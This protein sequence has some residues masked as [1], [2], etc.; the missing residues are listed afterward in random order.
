[1]EMMSEST[2]KGKGK[3]KGDKGK[4]K[5]KMKGKF[6]GKGKGKLKG[7]G[8]GK[9]KMVPRIEE[10]AVQELPPLSPIHGGERARNAG[11]HTIEIYTPQY[12]VKQTEMEEYDARPDRLGPS[13]IGK[14]TKGIGQVEARFC[15]DDEDPVS[16]AMTVVHRLAERINDKQLNMNETWKYSLDQKNVNFWNAVGRLD[17][18]TESI[19]DRSKSMK[20]YCMDLFE[21]YGNEW[22]IEGVDQYNAC[23]GGQ[24][25]GL[26]TL[27]WMQ[28]EHWDGRYGIAIATDISEAEPSYFA[29]VGACVSASL[30]YPDAPLA[31]HSLRA[32]CILHRF[33][34]CKPAGWISMAPVTEGKYS[35]E[36]YM[37]AI[38]CCYKSLRLKLGDRDV[39]DITD[40]NVFH[41]GGG[42]HIVRKAFDRLL[43]GEL[44]GIKAA[45]KEALVDRRLH[46]SVHLL[47][48]IGPVH[49]VSSFCNIS[50]VTMSE[51][52]NAIGKVLMVFTYGSGCASSI[53]QVRYDDLSYMEPLMVWKSKFYRHAIHMDPEPGSLIHLKYC[54]VWMKFDYIPHGRQDFEQDLNLLEEDVYYLMQI[55]AFGRRFYHRGGLKAGP[56]DKKW[57]LEV[58]SAESR[59]KRWDF[60]APPLPPPPEKEKTQDD[61]WRELELQVLRDPTLEQAGVDTLGTDLPDKYY[62]TAV[63]IKVPT[64][65]ENKSNPSVEPDGRRHTYQIVGSW[66][67]SGVPEEMLE[68][69]G[70]RFLFEFTMGENRFEQFY[71]IQD[72]DEKRRIYPYVEK[73]SKDMPCIGPHHGGHGHVWVVDG[74]SRATV[75]EEERG[76]PGDKYLI[77]FRWPKK[78]IKSLTW[79]RIDGQSSEPVA[80]QYYVCAS[81]TDWEFEEL[82]AV[83]GGGRSE[84]WFS[85]EVQMTSLGLE[86][87][88]VRNK[89]MS[90]CIYPLDDGSP[91]TSRSAI[92]GPD[93]QQATPWKI[94]DKLGAVYKISFF[95]DLEDCESTAMRLKWTKLGQR[96][97]VE[98]NARYYI[99]GDFN[100]W[101]VS[102]F[103][104]MSNAEK[105]GVYEAVVTYGDEVLA[106]Q[107]LQHK[108]PNRCLHPSVD[109]C[110]QQQ[111][112][113]V[114][115][116]GDCSDEATRKAW[117]IGKHVSDKAKQG[118]KFN[119]RLETNEK[120]FFVSWTR[121]LK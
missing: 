39:I 7:K 102:G 84:G 19:I 116:D 104:K 49:T 71:L 105:E 16:F 111:A 48:I 1:M 30:F 15:T 52:E 31:H 54:E 56:M 59:P 8:K 2:E 69:E 119:V 68:E 12:Y 38:D 92:C 36:C 115:M 97:V 32:S 57:K 29:F 86:F 64:E 113:E 89:S 46:P 50:S 62:G 74:R 83:E 6:K 90:E 22:N 100:N 13:V 23:Y 72:G 93:D 61:I 65:T 17:I 108:R 18:G 26:C 82:P 28:S 112:H 41:T 106:F 40:Y 78:S 70:S 20:S 55:D 110:A 98:Q 37:E 99:I 5:G 33:D 21:R 107:I 121:L 45:E 75:P 117:H 79:E 60:A 87:Y 3:D 114:L 91:I 53:Y 85:T 63:T 27:S 101:G 103:V 95:R 88:L 96:K 44:Q 76:M 67:R 51:W 11:F 47:K 34:F 43:R 73:S 35:V 77:T 118:T 94:D 10:Q 66:N 120:G 4:G 42:Y 14:Y 109:K 24:A 9:G 25:A 58:D 80:S 81:W